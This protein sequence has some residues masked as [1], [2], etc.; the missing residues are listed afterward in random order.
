MNDE[1]A[2]T[3]RELAEWERSAPPHRVAR[4]RA[5]GVMLA[6]NRLIEATEREAE[7][8]RDRG[9]R[10]SRLHARRPCDACDGEGWAFK[11]E[12]AIAAQ[13][14]TSDGGDWCPLRWISVR[15]R[16]LDPAQT[17]VRELARPVPIFRDCP[18]CRA[19]RLLVISALN[20]A[21]FRAAELDALAGA[22]TSLL[23]EILPTVE[24]I[25]SASRA[26]E[27]REERR[28]NT[29]RWAQSLK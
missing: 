28:T 5:L 8:A 20:A 14:E 10:E 29:E 22:L 16:K 27:W 11:V 25:V 13:G 26:A 3:P 12:P 6:L 1:R 17:V 21:R 7:R 4:V 9:L 18:T 2:A 19:R 24:R 15:P 23:L